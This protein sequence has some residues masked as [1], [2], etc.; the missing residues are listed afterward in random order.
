MVKI[1][2]KLT[3]KSDIIRNSGEIFLFA[4]QRVTVADVSVWAGHWSKLCPDIW[5]KD[6]VLSVML[7]EERGCYT[8]GA[9]VEDITK[10]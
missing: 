4:G 9:F 7:E 3:I 1:G 6:E 5:V 8:P 2:D 10:I